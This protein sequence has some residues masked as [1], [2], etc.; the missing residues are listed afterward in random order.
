MTCFS[1]SKRTVFT[2]NNYY[3]SPSSLVYTIII[4]G[5]PAIYKSG[6][7]DIG[8]EIKNKDIRITEHHDV[9]VTYKGKKAFSFKSNEIIIYNDP[10]GRPFKPRRE[11]NPL[12]VK[13]HCNP[14]YPLP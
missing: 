7:S 8:I 4:D 6:D 2:I 3:L 10:R 13:L 12:V 9:L 5:V 11:I 14:Y 1:T